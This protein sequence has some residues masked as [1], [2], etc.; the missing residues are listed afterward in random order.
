MIYDTTLKPVD[1]TQLMLKTSA[2]E[3][4]LQDIK[5]AYTYNWTTPR[6][7]TLPAEMRQ[8][9]LK[10]LKG[11]DLINAFN[12]CRLLRDDIIKVHDLSRHYVLFTTMPGTPYTKAQ[13]KAQGLRE[14]R[15][16]NKLPDTPEIKKLR[17]DFKKRPDEDLIKILKPFVN[18]HEI[19]KG[20]AKAFAFTIYNYATG[21]DCH[22]E[23]EQKLAA[24]EFMRRGLSSDCISEQ[25]CI[26]M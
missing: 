7:L 1:L 18:P 26:V 25:A 21:K 23:I 10:E 24:E 13:K 17:E 8:A 2:S 19:H 3:S 6:L 22:S 16:H 9:I 11:F 20:V 14:L 15:E 5:K 4:K 12:T